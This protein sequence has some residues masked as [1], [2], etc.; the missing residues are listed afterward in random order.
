MGEL[1][2]VEVDGEMKLRMQRG[3]MEGGY[4]SADGFKLYDGQRATV[5]RIGAAEVHAHPASISTGVSGLARPMVTDTSLP[6]AKHV[7][8]LISLGHHF[9]EQIV[10]ACQLWLKL[11]AQ[12]KGTP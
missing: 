3:M 2:R 5:G 12:M 10:E 9:Q 4:H 7:I 8:E 6:T 1:F 11:Q